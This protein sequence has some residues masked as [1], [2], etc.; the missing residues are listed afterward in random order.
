MSDNKKTNG[1]FIPLS[2]E[3]FGERFR[4]FSTSQQNS[5]IS[6]FSNEELGRMIRILVSY[7]SN[8]PT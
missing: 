7:D 6:S 4:G 2:D 1:K 3:K 8:K 5:P